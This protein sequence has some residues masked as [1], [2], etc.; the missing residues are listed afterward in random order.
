M[1]GRAVPQDLNLRECS[2]GPESEGMYGGWAGPH[3]DIHVPQDLNLRE[4]CRHAQSP[5]D[6]GLHNVVRVAIW[7]RCMRWGAMYAVGC[8]VCGGVSTASVIF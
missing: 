1:R 3:T 8:D 7:V 5:S 6:N 4:C 2:T